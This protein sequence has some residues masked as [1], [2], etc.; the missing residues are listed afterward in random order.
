MRL[1]FGVLT[2]FFFNNFSLGQRLKVLAVL[3][4]RLSETSGLV[5]FT[6]ST[7]LTLNDSGN[8]PE[9][10]E[11]N[12]RGRV[13]S[14]TTFSNASNFDWEELQMDKKGMIYIGDIGNNGH[15]RNQ[16]T[17]YKF[18]R[19]Y[20]GKSNVVTE[21]INFYYEDQLHFPPPADQRNFDAE[22]FLVQGD[23]L[24]IFSKDWSKPFT[25][26]SK[27]YFVPNQPGRHAAK[28]LRKFHTRGTANF[29]DAVT[30]VC[31]FGNEIL[32]LTYSSIY[33]IKDTNELLFTDHFVQSKRYLFRRIKQ[34]EAIAVGLDGKVYLTAERHRI[35]GRSKLYLWTGMEKK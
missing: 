24:F 33:H 25:G 7:F 13:V 17:I 4:N 18:D 1:L 31:W 30:G 26:D 12:K 32:L 11:I 19:D 8:K 16:L 2:L 28:L 3:E 9:L 23:S 15:A 6:D 35:L 34:F 27:L 10:Y 5:A 21:A 14:I 20:V 22:A 29:R